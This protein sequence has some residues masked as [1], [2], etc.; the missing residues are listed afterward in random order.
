[1]IVLI[2]LM[3]IDIEHFLRF[4]S[5]MYFI[6]LKLSNEV[7]HHFSTPLVVLLLLLL[8]FKFVF[9]L[10]NH[11]SDMWFVNSFP[12]GCL[13]ILLIISFAVQKLQSSIQSRLFGFT[14]VVCIQQVLFGLGVL[15]CFPMFSSSSVIVLGF[16]FRC[17]IHH[18]LFFP[19]SERY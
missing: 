14:F 6:F 2:S 18:E 11:L 5:H 16:K 9:I 3:A 10:V 7:F 1:M 12:I 15:E 17:S 8:F 19:D 13:F 4:I